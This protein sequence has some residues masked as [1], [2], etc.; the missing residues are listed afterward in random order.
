MGH[1]CDTHSMRGRYRENKDTTV[2]PVVTL[3]PDSDIL[4]LLILENSE[5]K[6]SH[7]GWPTFSHRFPLTVVQN[8]GKNNFCFVSHVRACDSLVRIFWAQATMCCSISDIGCVGPMATQKCPSH[9][10]L[11][12]PHSQIFKYSALRLICWR[13]LCFVSVVVCFTTLWVSY[14]QIC[15]LGPCFYLSRLTFVGLSIRRNIAV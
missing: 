6:H 15:K 4:L 9:S 11:T 5:Q 13:R 10:L 12:S 14:I 1:L 2:T 8:E 7:P 3:K